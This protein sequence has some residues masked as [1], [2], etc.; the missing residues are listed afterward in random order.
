MDFVVVE[1]LVDVP[2]V[3]RDFAPTLVDGEAGRVGGHERGEVALQ[4]QRA[5]D[6]GDGELV[7]ERDVAVGVGIHGAGDDRAGIGVHE[8]AV[9]EVVLRELGVERP[10]GPVVV[11][12]LAGHDNERPHRD[13]D[14]GSVVR[15]HR[16]A[17]EVGTIVTRK[18]FDHAGVGVEPG[19]EGRRGVVRGQTVAVL[20]DPVGLDLDRAGVDGVVGVVAVALPDGESVLVA[21]EPVGVVVEERDQGEKL[22]EGHWEPLVLGK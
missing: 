8:D 6:A 7:H 4:I 2:A 12:V 14:L 15:V 19:V 11:Q 20:V 22:S 17:A 5:R 18:G 1:R 9:L 21:I 16:P 13:L 3:A 10:A